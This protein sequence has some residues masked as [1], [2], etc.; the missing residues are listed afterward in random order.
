MTMLRLIALLPFVLLTLSS[1]IAQTDDPDAVMGRWLS[2]KKRNQIQIYKHSNTYTGKLV[3]MR[4]PTDPK[5]GKLKTDRQNP[6]EQLRSR[7]LL[8]LVIMSDLHYKGNNVWGDGQVYNPEDGKTY[9]C[10]VTLRDANSLDVRGYVLGITM[11]GKT[12]TWTR[13]K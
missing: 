7:P 6:N 10:E 5:T 13:V 4:E 12:N 3:W 1:S 9:G 11:L 2:S 8:D